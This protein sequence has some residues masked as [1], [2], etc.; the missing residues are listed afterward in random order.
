M[1]VWLWKQQLKVF[2]SNATND[3]DPFDILNRERRATFLWYSFIYLSLWIC[4][5]REPHGP[6]SNSRPKPHRCGGKYMRETCVCVCLSQLELDFVVLDL[7]GGWRGGF[8]SIRRGWLMFR[9]LGFYIDDTC[10]SSAL[11]PTDPSTSPTT[12]LF[13]PYR[14]GLF[15]SYVSG[16][17]KWLDPVQL[18]DFGLRD[19]VS[20]N[21]RIVCWYTTKNMEWTFLFVF[22]F[23]QPPAL[24]G[25]HTFSSFFPR[26][27][28]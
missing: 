6:S 20:V 14:K 12:D 23:T 26:S 21:A 2:L 22:R 19:L 11:R 4:A 16:Q 13:S 28:S 25:Y 3:N 5:S 10:S 17:S 1:C 9:K 7:S 27:F 8:N 18:G 24:N 15:L